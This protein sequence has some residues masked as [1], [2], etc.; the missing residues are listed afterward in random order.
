[1]GSAE[2]TEAVMKARKCATLLQVDSAEI[3]SAYDTIL[4][5]VSTEWVEEAEMRSHRSSRM[6]VWGV[7]PLLLDLK[8]AGPTQVSAVL[9]LAAYINAFRTEDSF[10]EIVQRLRD[11]RLFEACRFELAMAY[12]FRM[13]TPSVSLAPRV[14]RNVADFAVRWSGAEWICECA[15]QQVSQEYDR[16]EQV[17]FDIAEGLKRVQE[18]MRAKVTIKVIV[19]PLCN[20]E[21]SRTIPNK[22]RQLIKQWKKRPWHIYE[23]HG[24]SIDIKVYTFC[25]ADDPN[26]LRV[27]K[28]TDWSMIV[29]LSSVPRKEMKRRS[30]DPLYT[31]SS[32]PMGRTFVKLTYPSIDVEKGILKRTKAKLDQIRDI[33]DSQHRIILIE[34]LG[35]FDDFDW[36][37]LMKRITPMMEERTRVA[38]IGVLFRHLGENHRWRYGGG[39]LPNTTSPWSIPIELITALKQLEDSQPYG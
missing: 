37:S 7:H 14:G 22:V 3:A 12:R 11:P 29:D 8:I 35:C 18:E 4:K 23:A 39:I 24:N 20:P 5:C 16:I 26:P 1:M 10:V 13:V 21:A 33:S 30:N 38:G 27:G 25:D 9:E 2:I 32:P 6:G 17:A 19:A 28:D 31:R 36:Q 15:R 34:S